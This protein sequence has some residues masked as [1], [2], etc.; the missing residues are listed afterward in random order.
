VPEPILC[1][2]C[3]KRR[4]RRYCPA[5]Q[6]DICPL[7][8]GTHREIAFTCPLECEFLQEAHRHEKPAPPAELAYPEVAVSEEFLASQEELFMVCAHALVEGA[9]RVS[10]AID[11][12]LMSA[13][14]ALIQTHR[15]LDS[16]LLYETRAENALAASIQRSVADALDD[17]Q[18][19]RTERDPLTPVRNN[20]VLGVLVFLHRLG[21]QNR[22]GRPRGRMYL[23]LLR[24][25]VPP[26]RAEEP[27]PGIII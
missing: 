27:A 8:C 12:D 2:I 25:A 21:G 11:T 5:V 6:G 19:L 14:D 7:C 3:Q 23:D 22:N 4:A 10:G 26:A 24:H 13:L 20:E 17:Y 1:K 15:T 9:L 18:K 16:G